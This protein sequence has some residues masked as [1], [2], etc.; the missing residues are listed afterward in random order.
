MGRTH[1]NDGPQMMRKAL[2]AEQGSMNKE[3]T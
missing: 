3:S 1:M 2:K